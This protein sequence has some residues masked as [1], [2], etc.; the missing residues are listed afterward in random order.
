M[1]ARGVASADFPTLDALL[2]P[3]RASL[4]VLGG[5]TTSP[6]L[7]SYITD[8]ADEGAMLGS[9]VVDSVPA[10]LGVSSASFFFLRSM[11]RFFAFLGLPLRVVVPWNVYE[12]ALEGARDIE[13]LPASLIA[14]DVALPRYELIRESVGADCKGVCSPETP[15]SFGPVQ[16]RKTVS[17]IGGVKRERVR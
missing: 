8:G 12:V 7:S 6:S 16:A 15:R 11:T 9:G 17:R 3:N 4:G 1:E 14:L 2:L 13:S 10:S 5:V